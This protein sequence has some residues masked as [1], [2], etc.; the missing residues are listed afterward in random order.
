MFLLCTYGD[1]GRWKSSIEP[2]LYP[3]NCS[4]YR[5]FSYKHEYVDAAMGDLIRDSS[6][7]EEFLASPESNLGLFGMRFLD[8]KFHEFFIPL[9]FVSLT[10]CSLS[11]EATE[12]YFKLGTYVEIPATGLSTISLE[13]IVDHKVVDETTLFL[14]V[15]E[16]AKDRFA[17]LAEQNV[18]PSALTREL[19]S[20]NAIPPA[21]H[22]FFKDTTFI[23]LVSA[24][25]TQ[26]DNSFTIRLRKWAAKANSNSPLSPKSLRDPSATPVWGY[27]LNEGDSYSLQ[28]SYTRLVIR[29]EANKP[30]LNDYEFSGNDEIKV[31][32]KRLMISGN[33]REELVNVQPKNSNTYDERLVLIGV[34]KTDVGNIP[35]VSEDKIIGVQIPIKVD[36]V[37]WRGRVAYFI[38]TLL[39]GA[40]AVF[41]FF[42]AIT[43]ENERVQ[44][45]PSGSLPFTTI[46]IALGSMFAGLFGTSFYNFIAGTRK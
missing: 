8:P 15:P 21:S 45:R 14:Q 17:R 32:Q 12:I 27:R 11:G 34:R 23:R 41:C 42:F 16:D 22:L 2:L 29:A 13:G 46:L 25:K 43:I 3:V 36:S 1:S 44:S 9:R 28:F 40:L 31:S 38:L 6:K 30:F 24:T 18:F 39:F 7:F 33:Y 26:S 5:S 4:F 19:L 10:D 37:F 35:T 20:S